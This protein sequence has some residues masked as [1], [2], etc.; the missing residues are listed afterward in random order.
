MVVMF[1]G[2]V[3]GSWTKTGMELRDHDLDEQPRS[4]ARSIGRSWCFAF[5]LDNCFFGP[6]YSL[7]D[8]I[9]ILCRF[10]FLSFFAPKKLYIGPEGGGS[11]GVGGLAG[12]SLLDTYL[13]VWTW[14]I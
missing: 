1:L 14:Y 12:F 13:S 4:R 10:F 2:W 11:G 6:F 9:G 5:V 3:G 7:G 8:W